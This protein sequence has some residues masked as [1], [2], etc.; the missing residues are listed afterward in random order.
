MVYLVVKDINNRKF[1]LL[2][3]S[4]R[5]KNKITTK[6]IGFLGSNIKKIN[7]VNLKKEYNLNDLEI[8]KIKNRINREKLIS[9]IQKE[10]IQ[11]NKYFDKIQMSEINTVLLHKKN[12]KIIKK[13]QNNK[14]KLNILFISENS[15]IEGNTF[16]FKETK[17][18]LTEGVVSKRKN[19]KEIYNIIN[20]IEVLNFIK[21]EKPKINLEF[22]EK[23]HSILL[24]NIYPTRGFRNHNIKI[25]NKK[26][27]FS[28]YKEIKKEL[29]NLLKWF[30][31]NQDKIHP[32]ALAILFHN[33]FEKI[34]PFFLG[35]GEIGRI[36]MNYQ[37]SQFNYPPIII[38]RKNREEYYYAMNKAYP[39]LKKDLLSTDM[40]YYKYL[41]N[42]MQKCFVKT[43][44]ENIL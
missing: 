21:K 23:I 10:N 44:W 39:C 27:I 14:N 11:E 35:N 18:L 25:K 22:I 33:K 5:D 4:I 28:S 2:R 41:I 9:E 31:K 30:D 34:H 15:S 12:Y 36:I 40:K 13:L 42:F 38:K 19:I 29:I 6:D 17:K 24:N 43:Y 7:I 20:T 8:K 3:K 26:I 1:F 37:L 32:L 16:N